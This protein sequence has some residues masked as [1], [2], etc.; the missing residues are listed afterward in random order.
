MF[1]ISKPLKLLGLVVAQ[2]SS[3]TTPCSSPQFTM[4]SSICTTSLF[5]NPVFLRQKY[6]AEGLSA[7]QI[8]F[9]IGCAHSVINRALDK[10]K[11]KKSMRR[12][13]YAEYG[14]AIRFG[15]KVRH[16]RH[17]KIIQQM[18]RKKHK[19]WS[20]SRAAE[21]LNHREIPSPSGKAKWYGSTVARVIKPE[22]PA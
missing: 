6:E 12:P 8:A 5:K 4:K 22:L 18:I 7:R 21:W 2:E 1:I 3:C 20:D 10:Y 16:V 9:L 13:G 11:I 15:R 17:Q 19:G 14:W